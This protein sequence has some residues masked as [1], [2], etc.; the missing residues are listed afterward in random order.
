[1]KMIKCLA[2]KIEDEL[3]DAAE[4]VELALQY[5]SED[6]DTAELFYQLSTEEMGHMEKLHDRAEDLI[7]EYKE[8]HGEPPRD[9][10]TLYSYLHEK[11]VEK[12]TEIK[13]KQT[14][15]K[16]QE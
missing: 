15:Y 14:M 5:K 8:K 9:M 11:H 3:Q 2:E 7:E 6:P 16:M 12:A 10:L 4:Y 1:M 13:V